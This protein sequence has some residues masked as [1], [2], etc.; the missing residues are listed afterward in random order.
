MKSSFHKHILIIALLFVQVLSACT[1]QTPEP[2]I[3]SSNRV[4][5]P[6]TEVRQLESTATGRS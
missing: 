1:S 3:S 5:L 4:T 2:V 6:N